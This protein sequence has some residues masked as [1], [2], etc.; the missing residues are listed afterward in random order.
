M[1]LCFIDDYKLG[2]VDG[3]SVIDVS[4]EVSDLSAARPQGALRGVIENWDDSAVRLENA[5]KTGESM[6]TESVRFRPPTPRP[7]N[8]DCMAVNYM[9]NGTRDKPAMINAFHKS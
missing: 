1:K 9:E 5:V 2:V 6:S 4:G 7:T 3:E 8:I